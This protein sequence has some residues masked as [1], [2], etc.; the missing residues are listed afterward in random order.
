MGSNLKSTTADIALSS[1][2]KTILTGV[3]VMG[4]PAEPIDLK[5]WANVAGDVADGVVFPYGVVVETRWLRNSITN[6]ADKNFNETGGDTYNPN[7]RYRNKNTGKPY[8]KQWIS[9]TWWFTRNCTTVAVQMRVYNATN[10]V[11]KKGAFVGTTDFD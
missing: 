1:S 5:L 2:W 6:E 7:A 11:L 3:P 4:S 10:P 8:W 9:D